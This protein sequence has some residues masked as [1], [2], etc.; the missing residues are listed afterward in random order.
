MPRYF[1]DASA[2]VKR[3]HSESGR[4][5]VQRLIVEPG[6][7]CLISRLATVEIPS[8]FAGKVRTG[9]FL[10]TGYPRLRGQFLAD[11]K[12]RV[13]RPIRIVNADYQLAGDLISKH[14][15]SRQLRTLDAV[16]LA[17]AIR[18]HQALPLDEF[19]C[20]DQRLCDVAVLEGLAVFNP[21]RP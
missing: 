3:Y 15:M 16:H 12:R 18:L 1:F 11:V 19:V 21:E 10:S 9:V 14:G 8:G 7:E 20:A 4:T 5:E 2:V 13:L 17:I 6:A